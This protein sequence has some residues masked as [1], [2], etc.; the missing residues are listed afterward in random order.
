MT[1]AELAAEL[2]T[3]KATLEQVTDHITQKQDTQASRKMQEA[4]RILKTLIEWL[5]NPMCRFR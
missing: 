3:I 4:R 5:G 2:Q 1:K